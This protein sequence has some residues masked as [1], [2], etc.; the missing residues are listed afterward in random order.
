MPV[1]LSVQEKSWNSH[2]R[3]LISFFSGIIHLSD[4]LRAE[5]GYLPLPATGLDYIM[6]ATSFQRP[7]A[8]CKRATAEGGS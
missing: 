4:T 7:Q 5:N 2:H 1:M 3:P 6:V 8:Q